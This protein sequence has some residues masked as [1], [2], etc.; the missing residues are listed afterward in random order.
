MNEERLSMQFGRVWWLVGLRGLA[1][2]GLSAVLSVVCA[3]LVML[4]P[5]A[6]ALALLWVIA[7]YA[8]V[9]GALLIAFGLR[10]KVLGTGRQATA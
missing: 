2:V 3:V 5:G 4:N 6:G 10:L 1:G 9:F 7:A 8:I